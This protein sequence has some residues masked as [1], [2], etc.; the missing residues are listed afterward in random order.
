VKVFREKDMNEL[1]K[2]KLIKILDQLGFKQS[3][4]DLK[5]W[6][7]MDSLTTSIDDILNKKEE[8]KHFL[9]CVRH[10]A[11]DLNGS[12]SSPDRIRGWTD[13]PLND[14][15]RKD[16]ENAG[17]RLDSLIKHDK[18]LI[19]HSDLSRTKETAEIIK[20]IIGKNRDVKMESSEDLRP[21]NLGE[22]QGK[23]TKDVLPQ[24]NK[25][26]EEGKTKPKG[27]ESFDTFRERYLS[28]LNDSFKYL[29]KFCVVFVCHYRN[30]KISEAWVKNGAKKDYSIDDKTMEKDDIH[31]G[32]IIR[33]NHDKTYT[34]DLER[35]K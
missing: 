16:A 2:S 35:K 23:L 33:L 8:D 10:G 25:M 13:V 6:N 32:E 20:K 26:I 21:W 14:K 7:V 18:V 3:A 4:L 19:I 15:G 22:L 5:N 11:T 30:V 34:P 28:K 27:G 29:D 17:H 9:F 31:T 12:N 1:K 24:M